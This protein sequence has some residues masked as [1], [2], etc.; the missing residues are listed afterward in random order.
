MFGLRLRDPVHVSCMREP[1]EP[2]ALLLEIL[3]WPVTSTN[4]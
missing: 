1:K 4:N 2:R 3:L